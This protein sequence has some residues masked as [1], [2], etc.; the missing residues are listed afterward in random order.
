VLT[1]GFDDYR[2]LANLSTGAYSGQ[3]NVASILDPIARVPSTFEDVHVEETNPSQDFFRSIK[4][5]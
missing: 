5:W 2:S 1:F 3:F 4:E